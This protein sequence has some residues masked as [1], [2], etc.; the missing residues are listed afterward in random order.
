MQRLRSLRQEADVAAKLAA[1]T[2]NFTK[3]S[4]A[5]ILST[6]KVLPQSYFKIASDGSV[7][8]FKP[9]LPLMREAVEALNHRTLVESIQNKS[10]RSNSRSDL[11]RA[12]ISIQLR[13]V[14]LCLQATD[15]GLQ[16]SLVEAYSCSG[17]RSSN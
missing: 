1:A 16:T 17:K 12:N 4:L 13:R 7:S 6:R 14:T 2:I 3:C 8:G 15:S 9:D 5:T 11:H 10:A